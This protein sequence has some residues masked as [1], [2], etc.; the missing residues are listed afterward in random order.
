MISSL[1]KAVHLVSVFHVYYLV[2]GLLLFLQDLL[3]ELK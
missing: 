2:P 1:N 3:A